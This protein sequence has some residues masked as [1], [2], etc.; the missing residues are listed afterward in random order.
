MRKLFLIIF[1]VVLICT[2]KTPPQSEAEPDVQKIKE[3]VILQP[4][5]EIV[6]ILILQADLVVTEFETILKIT[7]PN[8]F[9]L[10]LSSLTYELFG[11]GRSWA[12]GSGKDIL[13]IPAKS[14]TDAKF[15]FEMNFINMNRRLLDDVI[16]MRQ[17]NYRFKG[18]AEVQPVNLL[19]HAFQMDYD[20]IGFSDV[21]KN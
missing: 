13:H 17:I 9:P 7:N 3:V 15:M 1:T 14:A 4:E 2:C 21:R 12:R 10:E 19:T 5:F 16:A 11:N 6:S 20:C 18:K 8:E